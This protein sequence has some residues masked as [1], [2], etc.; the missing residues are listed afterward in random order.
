M[1]SAFW[2]LLAGAGIADGKTSILQT[3]N[4]IVKKNG[5]YVFTPDEGYDG[6]KSVGLDAQ[7][8]LTTEKKTVTPTKET[9]KILP[10]DGVDALSEVDVEAIPDNYIDTDDGTAAEPQILAPYT[11]FVKGKKIAGTMPTYDGSVTGGTKG[12]KPQLN[13]PTISISGR[14]LKI[15]NPSTNGN[16]A[17]GYKIFVDGVEK[18]TQEASTV[19][20]YTYLDEE[21]TYH[22][23]AAVTAAQFED[24]AQ[25]TSLNYT[26]ESQ[27][28]SVEWLKNLYL[29][30]G[31]GRMASANAGKY[32]LFAGGQD[33]WNASPYYS[34]VDVLDEHL[35]VSKGTDLPT[36]RTDVA[37]ASLPTYALFAG[38]TGGGNSNLQLVYYDENLIQAQTEFPFSFYSGFGCGNE[39]YVIFAGSL[40]S[41]YN[42]TAIAY[43]NDLVQH[44]LQNISQPHFLGGISWNGSYFV[45]MGGNTNASAAA[46]VFDKD[47]THSVAAALPQATYDGTACSVGVYAIWAG[48][49]RSGTRSAVYAYD[50]ELTIHTATSLTK[51]VQ[52]LAS[53]TLNGKAIIG[54]GYDSSPTS[55][56]FAYDGNL[57]QSSPL[58]LSQ[59]RGY[60]SAVSNKGYAFFAGGRPFTG[61]PDSSN[62]IDVYIS[63]S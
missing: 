60:L 32:S 2:L 30:V 3:K 38:G 10:S 41:R 26:K 36:Q 23:S 12:A 20:L 49:Y 62:V 45:C 46:D 15:T 4:Y 35:T 54:G 58:G 57:T 1:A 13:A 63:K 5:T 17:E 6:F 56:V 27:S 11:A 29:S 8:A 21:G 59:A 43:D 25:S 28:T 14:Q 61:N 31:R 39:Q 22:L 7:V 42:T 47:L 40:D 52:A 51:A 55:N 37:G 34:D 33:K 19:D 16:F 18:S 9:Q 24:S 48:G 50:D 53:C 44:T